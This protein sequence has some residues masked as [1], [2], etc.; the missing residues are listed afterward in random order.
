MRWTCVAAMAAVVLG[1]MIFAPGVSAA[2]PLWA[3][4]HPE[5]KVLI[6]VDWQRAKSSPAGQLIGKQLRELGG[7]MKGQTEGLEFIDAVERILISAPGELSGNPSDSPVLIALQ[8]KLN[9][10]AL[11]SSMIPG[12]AVERYRGVDLLIPPRGERQ[13]VIAAIVNDSLTLLGD[14]PSIELALVDGKGM[15]D[16]A[17]RDRAEQ[18]AFNCEIWMIAAVPPMKAGA[19]A[20]ANPLAAGFD[21]VQAMDFGLA[22]ANGL[23]LRVNMEFADAAS[24]QSM[25]MGTQ[26]LTSMLTSGPS[27]SPEMARIARSLKVE[28]TGAQLKMN[29]DI[30]MD[31]LEK[32]VLQAKAGFEENAS[33]TLEGLL[34][35]SPKAGPVPGVR[36]SAAKPVEP[37]WPKEP[38]QRTIRIVGLDEGEREITYTVGGKR[39]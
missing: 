27:N 21:S 16:T 3:Y 19:A 14:R 36:P 28:Q 5:A 15:R 39:N 20:E 26:F 7:A 8:G 37:V 10:A 31:L 22:L 29:L 25:A 35:M 6:G 32:G 2:D 13:D 24:A 17:L 9:H 11:R 23:G 18:M 33:R 30:P 38:V 4:T 34:G 1:G 12:T